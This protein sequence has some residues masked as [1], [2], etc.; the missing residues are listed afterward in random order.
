MIQ[1]KIE[2]TH[3]YFAPLGVT[4]EQADGT[5]S[6]LL[7]VQRDGVIEARAFTERDSSVGATSALCVIQDAR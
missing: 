5:I 7:A 1:A 3:R 4:W 2:P 6:P